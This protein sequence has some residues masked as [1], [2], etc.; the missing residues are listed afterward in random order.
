MADGATYS[1]DEMTTA[2]TDSNCY[3]HVIPGAQLGWQC[4]LCKRVWS[5]YV[6]YCDCH[7]QAYGPRWGPG[8]YSTQ[9]FYP[10]GHTTSS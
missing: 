2:V 4:P 8:W 1:T 7:K 5:P 9:P 10:S 3:M 6:Q